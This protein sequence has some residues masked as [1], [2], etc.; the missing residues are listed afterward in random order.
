MAAAR[1]TP[2]SPLCGLWRPD[3]R[4]AASL[5]R[6]ESID[7]GNTWTASRVESLRIANGIHAYRS[8]REA[9]TG[10]RAGQVVSAWVGL[11]LLDESEQQAQRL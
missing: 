4:I 7:Q 1:P 10:V 9:F 2:R 11:P 6:Q 5:N 8:S 3:G